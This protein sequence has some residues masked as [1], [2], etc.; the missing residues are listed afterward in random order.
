MVAGR[1]LVRATAG[2]K[3]REDTEFFFA[4]FLC[5]SFISF[6]SQVTGSRENG[7]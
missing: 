4:G 5:S 3:S 2:E 1:R 7:K 6:N